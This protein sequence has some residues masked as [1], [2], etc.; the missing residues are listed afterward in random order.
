LTPIDKTCSQNRTINTKNYTAEYQHMC[1]KCAVITTLC[2]GSAALEWT[3]NGEVSAEM[4]HI[5]SA[6]TVLAS[7]PM[8]QVVQFGKGIERHRGRQRWNPDHD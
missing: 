3:Q 4:E 5:Q 8:E 2:L 1:C 7:S 6:N